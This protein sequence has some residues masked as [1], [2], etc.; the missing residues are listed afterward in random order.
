MKNSYTL[1]YKYRIETFLKFLKLRISNGD[2]KENLN[3]IID[4]FLKFIENVSDKE[5]EC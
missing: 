2:S 1:I 4:C 3:T 5:L